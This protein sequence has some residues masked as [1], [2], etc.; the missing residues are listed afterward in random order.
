M[1]ILVNENTRLLVQGMTGRAGTF[2]T[3]QAMRY[4][5]NCVAGVRPGRG[6]TSHL[7]LPVFHTCAEAVKETKANASLVTVPAPK[8][9]DAM[10]EAIEAEIEVVVCITERVPQHDMRRVKEALEGSQTVLIGPNSQGIL[11]PGQCKIGVMPTVDAKP[12]Q[13]GI[14][15]RS[16]SLTS[17]VLASCSAANLGQSTTVGVGGDVLHGIGFVGCLEKFRDD[18]DTKAVVLIGEM[19]G[20]EEELAAEY[21]SSVDYGKPVVGLVVGRHAP[22]GRRMG[23]AG[24]LSVFGNLSADDKISLLRDAGVVIARDAGTVVETV[25]SCLS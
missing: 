21:L 4:G 16:A 9:A 24:T 25:Q 6:G 22:V 1:A 2:Y 11:T 3:D 5:T 20:R 19:G 10:I 8:A 15:S 13:I 23:H 14:A 17:E 12:G 7:G 18:P